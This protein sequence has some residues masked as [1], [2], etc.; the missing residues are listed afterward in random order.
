MNG[1][2]GVA[3]TYNDIIGQRRNESLIAD[4]CDMIN[5]G[6]NRAAGDICSR[7]LD[8]MKSDTGLKADGVISMASF[9]HNEGDRLCCV[10]D[11]KSADVVR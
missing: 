5:I 4:R 7:L 9:F 10:S 8:S 2:P 6:L 1:S 11:G 3:D